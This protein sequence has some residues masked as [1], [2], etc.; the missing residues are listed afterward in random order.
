MR[1]ISRSTQTVD[2]LRSAILTAMTFADE[3]RQL[4]KILDEERNAHFNRE[5]ELIQRIDDTLNQP[6]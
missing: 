2:S 3:C 4:Q 5:Q 6:A 1:S